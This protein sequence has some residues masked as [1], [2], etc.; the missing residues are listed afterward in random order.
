MIQIHN[1]LKHNTLQNTNINKQTA[2]RS[3]WSTWVPVTRQTPLTRTPCRVAGRPTR[4][5][6]A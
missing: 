6:A 4:L 3:V 1:N 2:R 5:S